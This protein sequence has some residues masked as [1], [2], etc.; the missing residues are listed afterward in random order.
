MKLFRILMVSVLCVCLLSVSARA[1]LYILGK[2]TSGSVEVCPDAFIMEVTDYGDQALFTFTNNCDNGGVL[3]RI[4][5]MENDLITFDSIYDQSEGVSFSA[6][7]KENAMLP[8]GS[9]L[10]F[11]P[12]NTYSINAD[13]ARPKNGLHYEDYVS[14]LFDLSAGTAFGDVTGALSGAEL[15]VGIHV[16]SLPGG[17]SASFAVIPE[18]ATLLLVGMGVLLFKPKKRGTAQ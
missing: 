13:P 2:I 17:T 11:S 8:G 4:F 16:Q 15:G 1:E 10:G 5:V 18:P 9:E 6:P 12:Q 7:V 14:V 3:G